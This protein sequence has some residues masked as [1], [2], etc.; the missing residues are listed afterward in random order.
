M[1][2]LLE[3]RVAA[4]LNDHGDSTFQE[5]QRAIPARAKTLREILASPSFESRSRRLHGGDRALVYRLA[6]TSGKRRD[7]SL[8]TVPTQKQRILNILRDGRWHSSAELYRTGCVLHSRISDLRNKDGFRI[9]RRNVGGVG[10]DAH[11]YRLL[12]P[13]TGDDTHGSFPVADSSG[14]PAAS[15]SPTDG[16]ADRT[17]QAAQLA[18]PIA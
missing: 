15:T 13:A 9:E 4:W 7:A 1:S 2:A 3:D 16:E 10:A 11:E 8:G 14:L 18:L 5:V 6:G 12:E 17:G